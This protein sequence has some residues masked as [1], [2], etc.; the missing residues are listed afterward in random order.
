MYKGCEK[1]YPGVS[2]LLWFLHIVEKIFKGTI[3]L[4]L[5]VACNF[6]SNLKSSGFSAWLWAAYLPA[7]TATRSTR[8][9]P[10]SSSTD[11]LQQQTT[12]D[13][14]LPCC[15]QRRRTVGEQE[16]DDV[17]GGICAAVCNEDQLH[18]ARWLDEVDVE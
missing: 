15:S 9:A 16:T 11:C 17:L 12:R 18:R 6:R 4:R 3:F 1:V 5:L 8:V 7:Q 14:A 13:P 2:G 10:S